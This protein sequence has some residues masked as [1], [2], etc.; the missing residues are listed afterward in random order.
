MRKKQKPIVSVP[1]AGSDPMYVGGQKLTGREGPLD[2]TLGE[3][4]D[5]DPDEVDARQQEGDGE[6][7]AAL[8]EATGTDD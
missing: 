8:R 2:E 1:A 4:D 7:R 6:G 3:L 5:E